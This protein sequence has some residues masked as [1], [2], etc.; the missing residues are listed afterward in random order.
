MNFSNFV[1]VFE[2]TFLDRISHL[3]LRESYKSGRYFVLQRVPYTFVIF[4][5]KGTLRFH[6]IPKFENLHYIRERTPLRILPY[7]RALSRA[8]GL[9][10]YS[11]WFNIAPS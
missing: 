6:K 11:L 10:F 9:G 8:I 2:S 5:K 1:F 4:L 7:F 3:Q